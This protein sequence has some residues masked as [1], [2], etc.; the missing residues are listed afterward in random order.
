MSSSFYID[1]SRR[2]YNNR[3]INKEL[4]AQ[5]IQKVKPYQGSWFGNIAENL[6]EKE[7]H[8]ITK[9]KWFP[10]IPKGAENISYNY[11]YEGFLPDYSF[12]LS[13][14][15]PISTKV[16]TMH[17]KDHNFSKSRTF[18]IVNNKKR[19]TYYEGQW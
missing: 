8:E 5:V 1:Y 14:D 9:I 6:T 3:F 4:R 12:S 11:E 13:Y 15:L 10:T 16:D 18:E 19:I 7:Y 2:I 17:Y